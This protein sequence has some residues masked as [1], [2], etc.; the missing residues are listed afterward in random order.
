M[1]NTCSCVG[2]GLGHKKEPN[3]R[4]HLD[5]AGGETLRS[6]AIL[7][8]FVLFG[9]INHMMHPFVKTLRLSLILFYI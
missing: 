4:I 8:F 2:C 3:F 1:I 6:P 7:L 9:Q 5:T